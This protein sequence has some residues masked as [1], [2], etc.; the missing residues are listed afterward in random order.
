MHVLPLET[1]ESE[2]SFEPSH[3]ELPKARMRLHLIMCAAGPSHDRIWVWPRLK[4]VRSTSE[5]ADRYSSQYVWID[6]FLSHAWYSRLPTM[7]IRE[8]QRHCVVAWGRLNRLCRTWCDG[9]AAKHHLT[10]T[11][12]SVNMGIVYME[13]NAEF[14][15][16]HMSRTRDEA[17]GQTLSTQARLPI[18]PI[19]ELSQ[20]M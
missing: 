16:S 3:S 1:F 15:R 20:F 8:V 13:A 19:L 12:R 10:I 14:L 2:E 9:H 17:R 6:G 4:Y 7:P 5:Y 18:G 11:V